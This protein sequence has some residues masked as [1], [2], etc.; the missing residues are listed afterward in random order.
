MYA[1]ESVIREIVGIRFRRCSRKIELSADSCSGNDSSI[2]SSLTSCS[3]ISTHPFLR[4][5]VVGAS[6]PGQPL[7][8][9]LISSTEKRKV[10]R[11]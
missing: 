10:H 1:I 11:L 5:T 2:E 6:I 3:T 9:G 8:L 7:N 4:V